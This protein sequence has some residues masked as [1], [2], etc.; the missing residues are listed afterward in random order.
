MIGG[1][2]YSRETL[3]D[4]LMHFTPPLL[5]LIALILTIVLYSKDRKKCDVNAPSTG[6]PVDA[7][8]MCEEANF[9][10]LCESMADE[11]TDAS[12][13][14]TDACQNKMEQFKSMCEGM[15]VDAAPM[16]LTY[17]ALFLGQILTCY[18][19]T[20]TWKQTAEQIED[21]ADQY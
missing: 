11:C 6:K 16:Y 12:G 7:R 8:N 10:D 14:A 19:F 4:G 21:K 1:R 18:M 2:R 3:R 15:I 20:Q 13:N 5:T 9:P 17:A